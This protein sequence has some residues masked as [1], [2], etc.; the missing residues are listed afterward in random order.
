MSKKQKSGQLTRVAEN[1]KARFRFEIVDRMECGIALK[2]TEVKSLRN[3]EVSLAEAYA[4]IS[5][6]G[7]LWLMEC[8]INPYEAG[9]SG[10]QEPTRPRKLLAHRREIEK[11]RPQVR[12]KGMTMVPLELYFSSRGLAKVVIGL[13]RGKTHGDKRQDVKKREHQREMN[14][15]T[16]RG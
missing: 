6:A 10:N 15:A 3:K 8:H 9:T 4:R 7:E 11:W 2:G 12:A 16:R 1:R 5:P 14:R 13:V